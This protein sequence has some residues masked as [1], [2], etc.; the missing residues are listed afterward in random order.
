MLITNHKTMTIVQWGSLVILSVLW[1]GSFFFVEIALRDLPVLTIVLG[2]VSLAA[3]ILHILIPIFGY[4]FPAKL[5]LWGAFAIMGMLNNFMPFS[6]I[7]WGQSHI[8]SGLA[9]IL[10]ATTPFFSVVFAHYLTHNERITPPR[11]IGV[12][13]GI[14]GVAVMIGPDAL[15]DLQLN[16]IA[17]LAIL[18]AAISYALAGLF[19][20]RFS[21]YPPLVTA[22]GQVSATSLMLLPI[23]LYVDTPWRLNLP[24]LASF[25][26]VIGLALLCTVIAYV[27]YFRLL[28]RVGATNLLLVTFL[29]PVSA[30]LL[31]ALFLREHL[32]VGAYIGIALIGLGLAA[33]DGRVFALIRS[34]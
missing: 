33:I 29:I 6:L 14:T 34:K 22:A 1:G 13:M 20:R 24:G 25:G 28:A 3:L 30:I 2:R 27:I 23:V 7:V 31:G 16:T 12:V 18:G 17:Q 8:D 10:N 19:G 32:T 26:A 11:M 4:R 9:S 15:N 21:T 5:K